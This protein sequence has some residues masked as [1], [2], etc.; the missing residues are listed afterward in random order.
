MVERSRREVSVAFRGG[1]VGC[2]INSSRGAI[3][4]RSA[5]RPE[6]CELCPCGVDGRCRAQRRVGGEFETR[7][8]VVE[9]QQVSGATLAGS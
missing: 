2:G 7:V 4:G 8:G 5:A 9:T 6:I 3:P 1:R